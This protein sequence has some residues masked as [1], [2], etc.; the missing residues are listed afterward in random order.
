MTK[1]YCFNI[2]EDKRVIFL[3]HK[4]KANK[5]TVTYISILNHFSPPPLSKIF[6]NTI[7]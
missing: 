4:R 3:G 2:E 7:R 6:T 5:M 1:V